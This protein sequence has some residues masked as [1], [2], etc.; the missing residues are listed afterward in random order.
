MAL[1]AL[2]VSMDKSRK[3]RNVAAVVAKETGILI[4]PLTIEDRTALLAMYEEFE[5]KGAADGLPPAHHPEIWLDR[6][7]DSPNLIALV[8]DRIVGHAILCP[9]GTSGELAVFVHQNYRNQGIGRRLLTGM[10]EEAG[11]RGLQ[12]VW[13]TTEPDNIGMI[14]LTGEMGFEPSARE[15]NVFWVRTKTGA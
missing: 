13:G 6:V 9:E 10:M 15:R 11:R 12:R 7:A 3:G 8:D 14:R 5:P 4:R 2:P 1:Q